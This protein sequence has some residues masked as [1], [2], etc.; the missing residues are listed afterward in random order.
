MYREKC[1]SGAGSQLASRL[2]PGERAPAYSVREPSSP[3]VRFLFFVPSEKRCSGF[4][5]KRC[6]GLYSVNDQKPLTGGSCPAAKLI[7]YDER[8]SSGDPVESVSV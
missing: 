6:S 8:P 3:R 7:S 4:G 1:R 2:C 5:W